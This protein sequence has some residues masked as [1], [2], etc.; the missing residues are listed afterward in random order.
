MATVKKGLKDNTFQ[1]YKYMYT[2]FVEPDFGCRKTQTISNKMFKKIRHIEKSMCLF[3]NKKANCIL[4]SIYYIIH[5]LLL[6]LSYII[7]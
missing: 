1:N 5:L 4:I 7:K 6:A 2:Q 3:F